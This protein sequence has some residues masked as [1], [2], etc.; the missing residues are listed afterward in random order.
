MFEEAYDALCIQA[1]YGSWLNTSIIENVV[2][3]SGH[4]ARLKGILEKRAN[5]SGKTD[6]TDAIKKLKDMGF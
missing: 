1:E 4:W 2:R 5:P 3:K 6:Y